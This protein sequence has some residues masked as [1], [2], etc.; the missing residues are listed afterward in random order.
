[1]IRQ[2]S[3]ARP[4]CGTP[5][6]PLSRSLVI[7]DPIMSVAQSAEI[8]SR[9]AVDEAAVRFAKNLEFYRRQYDGRVIVTLSVSFH[10]LPRP[11]T[12]SSRKKTSKGS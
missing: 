8:T 5:G 4:K 1:M 7:S 9:G 2:N 10:P 3:P 12:R 6:K 11:V